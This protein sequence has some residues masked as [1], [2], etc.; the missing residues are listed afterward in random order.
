MS[1]SELVWDEDALKLLEKVPFFVRK[2]AKRKIEKTAIE[3][4]KSR[5]TVKLME[6]IRRERSS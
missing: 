4:S 2:A 6:Q 1:K 5:V 3:S